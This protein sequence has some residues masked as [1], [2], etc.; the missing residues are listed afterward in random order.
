MLYLDYSRS[1]AEWLPNV[2]GGR[3]NLEAVSFLQRLNEDVYR[4]HSGVQTFAEESTAWP[5]VSRPTDAGGLGFGAKWDMGWMHDTLQHLRR[6][7]IHRR[8][9]HGELTFRQ[10]YAYSENFV[11]PLSHDEVVH[12]KGSL[13][14]K[15]PGDDW[16]RF[17]TV[18]LLLGY[19]WA[20]PG[21]EL[22]FMGDELA[23]PGEWDHDA[24]VP[25]ELADEPTHAG[26]VRWVRDLNALMREEPA[27]HALD[28]E[29]AGFEW[30][31]AGD[32]EGG[33]LAFLRRAPEPHRPVA[34]ALNLTPMAHE[35][36]RLGLPAAGLWREALNS[37]AAIY[38]GSGMGNLGRVRA[39]ALPWHGREHSA[40]IVLPPLACVIFTPGIDRREGSRAS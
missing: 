20:L 1:D 25:W 10:V 22:L 3:E 35:R 15:M 8:Y 13:L 30:I 34:V 14:G 32:A 12:G 6:E 2:H 23:Q 5:M 24:S 38:G 39:E 40:R 31:E 21:K 9:H 7:P 18:R 26:V 36:Y 4:E 29:P 19:Q 11:L 33:T 17:A 37:D 27:L 16:Q 28:V